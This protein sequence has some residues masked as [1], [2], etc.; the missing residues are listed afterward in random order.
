MISTD[1]G[2]SRINNAF[3][4]VIHLH[5]SIIKGLNENIKHGKHNYQGLQGGEQ[6]NI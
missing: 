2:I 4:W 5:N 6:P 3:Q 1:G